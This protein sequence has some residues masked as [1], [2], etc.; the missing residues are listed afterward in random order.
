VLLFSHSS[1]S[2]ASKDLHQIEQLQLTNVTTQ[3]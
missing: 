2:F 1:K 3:K